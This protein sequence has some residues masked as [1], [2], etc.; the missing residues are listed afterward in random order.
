MAEDIP[1]VITPLEA[2]RLLGISR[3][4]VYKLLNQG[5]L[6]AGRYGSRWRV[7]PASVHAYAE[8]LLEPQQA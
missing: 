8:S 2:A 5:A 1:T 6:R 4:E 7:D 3:T